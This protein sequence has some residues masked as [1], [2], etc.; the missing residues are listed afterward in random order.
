MN[1]QMADVTLGDGSDME[2]DIDQIFLDDEEAVLEE[3]VD[4]EL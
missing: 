3:G 2:E 1:A 4:E